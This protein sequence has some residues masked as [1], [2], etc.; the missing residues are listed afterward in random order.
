MKAKRG[1]LLGGV[2][3]VAVLAVAGAGM[4]ALQKPTPPQYLTE[5]VTVGDLEKAVL[6]T[7]SLQPYEVINVG[8]ETDGQ[9]LS[10]DVKLGDHVAPGQVIAQIDPAQLQNQLRNAQTR[11]QERKAQVGM[12]TANLA[13][14]QANVS[15]Q[16]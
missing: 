14:N 2:G 3:V 10:V 13:M 1:L 5:Q 8:S 6:A 4:A 7:G 15:R 11:L 16:T 12:V 9:V